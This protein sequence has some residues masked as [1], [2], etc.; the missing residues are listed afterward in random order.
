MT[1]KIKQLKRPYKK[2]SPGGLQSHSR[3]YDYSKTIVIQVFMKSTNM[4]FN[5]RIKQCATCIKV[6]NIYT[7]LIFRS[8]AAKKFFSV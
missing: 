3:P 8:I 4:L 6:L 5:K 7:P 1:K 2:S